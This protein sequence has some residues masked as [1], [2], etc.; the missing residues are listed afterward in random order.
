[1]FHIFYNQDMVTITNHPLL[2]SI[3]SCIV[4][5]TKKFLDNLFKLNFLII[6]LSHTANNF[7][8]EKTTVVLPIISSIQLSNFIDI[9]GLVGLRW[10][11]LDHSVSLM[12]FYFFESTTNK[13]KLL[14]QG[15]GYR[16]MNQKK[17]FILG[18]HF[19]VKKIFA[20]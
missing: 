3:T 8:A 15:A 10:D 20:V 4:K 19:F 1:M 6:F 5:Q 13:F 9:K 18:M 16:F 14:M 17:G 7:C 2:Y 12:S 11:K